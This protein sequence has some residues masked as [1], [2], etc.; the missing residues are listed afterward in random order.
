MLHGIDDWK[1]APASSCESGNL[2]IIWPYLLN[3]TMAHCDWAM[4]DQLF[5]KSVAS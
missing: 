1:H 4:S 5:L 2:M 3:Y